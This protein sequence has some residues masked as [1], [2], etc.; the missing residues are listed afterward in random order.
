MHI[1]LIL[2]L[3][4]P[5]FLF[6][7]VQSA[8]NALLH[9][10]ERIPAGKIAEMRKTLL[11]FYTDHAEIT[12]ELLRQAANV[13]YRVE[14]SDFCQH[15]ERVVELYRTQLGGLVE[16]ERLWREHFLHTMQPRFLPDLWNVNHNA[17]RLEVRA[18]EGRVDEADLL[19]AGV[20]ARPKVG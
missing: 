18:T 9:H 16:L 4:P 15:G 7:R 1:Y 14:N 11:D 17:D 19:V 6:R 3:F 10:G 5:F 13:E 12:E 20:D 2:H 8:G